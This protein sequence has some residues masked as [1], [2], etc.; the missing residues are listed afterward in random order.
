MRLIS[1]DQHLLPIGVWNDVEIFSKPWKN[2]EGRICLRRRAVASRDIRKCSRSAHL[3]ISAQKVGRV[4]PSEPE[5][6][7]EGVFGDLQRTLLNV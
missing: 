1:G 6:A 3:W 7:F 4:S 5:L 2:S